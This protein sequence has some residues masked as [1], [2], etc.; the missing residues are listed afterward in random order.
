MIVSAGAADDENLSVAVQLEGA[1]F[2]S[3]RCLQTIPG[4]RLILKQWSSVV[5]TFVNLFHSNF[6]PKNAKEMEQMT[7]VQRFAGDRFQQ[8]LMLFT[9]VGY[10][11]Y[12]ICERRWCFFF[13][14]MTDHFLH[15]RSARIQHSINQLSSSVPLPGT[16]YT[17]Y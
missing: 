10:S 1:R 8:F 13:I 17:S 12:R 14:K 7:S 5:H 15:I 6:T 4:D 2:G 9:L 11:L 3:P 16:I